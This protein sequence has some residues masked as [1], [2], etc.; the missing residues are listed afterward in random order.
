MGLFLNLSRF[1]KIFHPLM[2][3]LLKLPTWADKQLGR[4]HPNTL[5]EQE[6]FLP[7]TFNDKT[8]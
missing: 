8:K 5:S 7:D 1:I 2:A 4:K 6:L 3:L